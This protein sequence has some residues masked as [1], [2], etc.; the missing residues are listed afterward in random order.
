MWR[1]LLFPARSVRSIWE[2]LW[3]VSMAVE[4]ATARIIACLQGTFAARGE[5]AVTFGSAS[6][7]SPII[8]NALMPD[9]QQRRDVLNRLPVQHD[10]WRY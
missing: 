10:E 5:A 6:F 7:I 2:M 4:L 8:P 9:W 3:P 1:N